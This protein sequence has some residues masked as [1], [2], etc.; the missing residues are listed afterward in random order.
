MPSL[1]CPT[2]SSSW[3]LRWNSNLFCANSWYTG[4]SSMVKIDWVRNH[5][6]FK[7]FIVWIWIALLSSSGLLEPIP[8]LKTLPSGP[9]LHQAKSIEHRFESKRNEVGNLWALDPGLSERS[10]FYFLEIW[11]RQILTPSGWQLLS[12]LKHKFALSSV[13]TTE[14]LRNRISL[15]SISL[16]TKV[17]QLGKGR[18][19]YKGIKTVQTSRGVV[20]IKQ[21]AIVVSK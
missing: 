16:H 17:Y 13:F 11:I 7:S 1:S 9:Q 15:Y 14:L 20:S 18:S 2:C 4:A 21:H 8:P 6:W 19:T 10:P 12:Q 5:T 3:D